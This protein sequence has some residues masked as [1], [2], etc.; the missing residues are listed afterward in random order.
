MSRYVIYNFNNAAVL[1]RNL[2]NAGG[3][4]LQD[5]LFQATDRSLKDRMRSVSTWAKQNW[6]P[7]ATGAALLGAA[8]AAGLAGVY[9]DDINNWIGDHMPLIPQDQTAVLSM[10]NPVRTDYPAAK[11]TVFRFLSDKVSDN[12]TGQFPSTEGSMTEV[13]YTPEGVRIDPHGQALS[14]EQA[15]EILSK[16]NKMLGPSYTRNPVYQHY[17]LDRLDDG[18][19]STFR[20][21]EAYRAA[22]AAAREA[23][24]TA[25]ALNAP[26]S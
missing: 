21:A 1:D 13:F 6:K 3:Y 4:Y 15:K 2:L 26:I 22:K 25:A 5:P 7:L 16:T 24:K 12:A 11:E 18:S 17:K 9:A 14:E 8:G 19:L 20:Q 23:A 10:N